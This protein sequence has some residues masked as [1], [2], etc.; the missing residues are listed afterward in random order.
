MKSETNPN[1]EAR[2]LTAIAREPFVIRNL[3]FVRHSAFGIR[4]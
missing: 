2:K 3:L 4:H 1:D